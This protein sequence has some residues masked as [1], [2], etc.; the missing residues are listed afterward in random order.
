M[1]NKLKPIIK[2]FL[3][4]SDLPTEL[5]SD[6][7]INTR[8][9]IILTDLNGQVLFMNSIAEK[10]LG[11]N[12][13]M[14]QDKGYLFNFDICIL[15]HEIDIM[16]YSPLSVAIENC[17]NTSIVSTYEAI[18]GKEK[19]ITVFSRY[20]PYKG[21][22]ISLSEK[23]IDPF[24][25]A[26]K[27]L[28][29]TNKKLKEKIKENEGLRSQAQ[30]QAIRESL[31]NKI[32]NSLRSTLEIDK[33]LQS[34]VK[35]LGQTLGTDRTILLQNFG[36]LS[37]LP[38]TQ[39]YVSPGQKSI[40]GE[41]LN[42]LDDF[43]LHQVLETHQA[44]TGNH[45][46]SW[47][48]MNPKKS[49]LIV[50]IIH[51]DELFGIL[52]LLRAR[53]KWHSEEIN[54]VQSI[55]DQI[56]VSIKNA[57]LYEDTTS[58]NTKISVL[59]EIL[60]SIN[61]S[62]ILD[63]VFYTIGREIKRLIDFDR[64]SIA[65]LE[66]ETRQVKLFARIKSTGEIE[67][68]R[69][70]PLI[71]KGT[72]IGWAID[73]LKP[74][75]INMSETDE[76]TDTFTLKQS[77]IKTAIIIPMITKGKVT[78]IFYIGSQ[79]EET[80]SDAEVE[81]MSQI[82]GQ[83]AVAVENAKLYWQTQ[84]QALKE[85]LINQIVSSIRKSL[86][87]KDVFEST[88]RELTL[89]LGVDNCLIKYYL[90]EEKTKNIY[91]YSQ[92]DNLKLIDPSSYIFEILYNSNL[93]KDKDFVVLK[94]DKKNKDEGIQNFIIDNNL[95]SILA[96]PI[97]F[98]DPSTNRNVNVAMILLINSD[99][100]R[101]W[102]TEDLNLLKVLSDQITIIVNQSRLFEQSEKQKE[103][104]HNALLKLK[105]AQSQLVQS[106]KMAALGQLVA[107]VAHEIN[108]P[109]GS[110]NSNNSI[111]DKC[112]A[113]IKAC[114][115]SE[116][117]NE[118]KALQL[119]QMLEETIQFNSIA[120]ER[121]NDIVKSLK[122]FARLDESELK[123]VNIHEGIESTLTLLRH[124]LKRKVKIVKEFTELP[125]VECYPNLLNQVF[126]NLLVNAIQ[127]IEGEGTVTIA[128]NYNEA[129]VFITIKDTGSGI[130]K[131]IIDKIFDPGFTTKGVGVGT[132]LGLSICYQIIEKHKGL[133]SVNSDTEKGSTFTITIPIKQ[134]N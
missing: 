133:I 126:M 31:I 18:P 108:T 26:Y 131:E 112:T 80:Y 2:D 113:K 120:C 28:E 67:I 48:T 69:S 58:K 11:Q 53:R 77:G 72:A 102:S 3:K 13:R 1:S 10:M 21:Y 76:F 83:I 119:I 93:F 84:T 49:K 4:C 114:L 60:K 8:E 109:I 81:I 61:S 43:F 15:D 57:K 128:T 51:Q 98:E 16:N 90:S 85:T 97:I 17:I 50:P 125:D 27:E 75:L 40:K 41:H 66:D 12:L 91:E 82:A 36:D 35:E 134:N 107:G 118:K 132:G 6:V 32:S 19:N 55:A 111:F 52:F 5:I 106:E 39:E 24:G 122:N 124:E 127:S 92:K 117:I 101:E 25:Q 110:I 94:N 96:I 46:D 130:P 71:A 59:N 34:A 62:L 86:I 129:D 9:S 88:A 37:E 79:Y 105:D 68:L 115:E 63:D 95:K 121:I 54:L 65:I 73:N 70:G 42:T 20:I 123:K 78:G 29:N 23:E 14:I 30:S 33:I 104:I 89:A 74:I 44:S 22:I 45:V 103:E 7:F 47:D 38:I 99:I 64:A 116:E 87:L 100:E 56:S